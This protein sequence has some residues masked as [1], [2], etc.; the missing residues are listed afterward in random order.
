MKPDR[1]NKDT[2]KALREHLLYLLEGGGAHT[3]F[4]E[5]VAGIPPGLH[6]TQPL[7]RRSG[8]AAC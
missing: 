2:D 7:L 5:V 4:D 8:P 3:K 1:T 6:A